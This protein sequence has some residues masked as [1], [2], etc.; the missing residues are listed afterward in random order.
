M[1]ISCEVDNC[2]EDWWYLPPDGY[3]K[4]PELPRRRR[5]WSCG[6]FINPGDCVAKFER[7]RAASEWYQDRFFEDEVHAATWW[8]CEECADLFFS[9]AEL[10]YIVTISRAESMREMV[11]EYSDL[12]EGQW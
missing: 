8:A 4:M 6:E 5:C 11:A 7:M 2:G 9:V 12:T 10:G 3:E 1:S